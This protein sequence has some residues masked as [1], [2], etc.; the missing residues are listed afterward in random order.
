MDFERLVSEMRRNAL[1]AGAEIM[2]I[3]EG[4]ELGVREKSDQSPVTI[5][6]EAADALIAESMVGSSVMGPLAGLAIVSAVTFCLTNLITAKAA[7]V[8]MLPIALS[9]AAALSCDG[10][11]FAIAV[12]V[13]GASSFATPIGYQTNLMVYGPGGY[14]ATDFLRLGIPL[15]FI[16]WVVSLATIPFVWPLN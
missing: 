14:R 7:A 8:L 2:K 3:Y 16:V 9:T 6:D 11:P 4:G 5:A 1:L 15:S 13:A 10:T 12:M